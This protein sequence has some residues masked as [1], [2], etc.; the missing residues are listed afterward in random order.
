MNH[1]MDIIGGS[2]GVFNG[3][4]Q[5]LVGGLQSGM[6]YSN[7][8]NVDELHEKAIFIRMTPGGQR[9]S[10]PHDVELI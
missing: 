1:A 9:E 6:S 8:H 5:Q 4:R 3:F 10:S 7:A 2:L